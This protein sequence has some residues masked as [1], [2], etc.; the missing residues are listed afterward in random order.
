[1][2]NIHQYRFILNGMKP[3]D[4]RRAYIQSLIDREMK[5]QAESIKENVVDIP[6]DHASAVGKQIN[7]DK[8]EVTEQS[9]CT[10]CELKVEAG[11]PVEPKKRTRKTNKE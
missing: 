10:D 2:N 8:P 9:E 1:M 5:Q 4:P 11:L 3:N 6:Y 7:E